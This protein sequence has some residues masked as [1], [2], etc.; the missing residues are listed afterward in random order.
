M[1][2]MLETIPEEINDFVSKTVVNYADITISMKEIHDGNV[3][4]NNQHG[5]GFCIKYGV[6]AINHKEAGSN[7]I[8][9][10]FTISD[11]EYSVKCIAHNANEKYLEGALEDEAIADMIKVIASSQKEGKR[12]ELQ[13]HYT[14]VGT[15]RL[16]LVHCIEL[17]DGFQVSQMTVNQFQEFK[18]LCSKYDTDPLSLMMRDDTLWAE[19]YAM[20]YLK[21]AI[22]LFC[23]SPKRKQDMIHVGIVSSHGEGKDHLIERVIQPLVPCRRAGSGKMATIPGL[24]GAMSGDD[25]NAIEVGLLPKMNHERVAISEFQTWGDETFGELMNMMANG[26]IEMQ[27]GALD[28]ERETTL[29]LLFLGNPPNYYTEDM[30]KRVMLD[31]FGKYTFQI[32]SRLTLIFTQLS[33]SDGKASQRIRNAII[34]AMDGDFQDSEIAEQVAKWR[35]FF[36]EYLRFVSHMTPKLRH[37]AGSINGTYDEIEQKPH[38]KDAFC[39][40]TA[41]DNRKYQ[42]FANL[43]RGFARLM[44]D[45][46]IELAHL[47]SAAQIFELSLETLTEKFPTKAWANGVDERLLELYDCIMEKCPVG[48]NKREIQKECSISNDELITLTKLKALTRFDDGT[49]FVNADWKKELEI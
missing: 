14:N 37:F 20:D 32:I 48:H 26:Q 39:I 7:K 13:G 8:M 25:L 49:Y 33:L 9:L 24:F 34:S 2:I 12:V 17:D 36:R 1:D 22:L 4:G 31:A 28:V 29:N 3:F 43:V 35:K 18:S 44:G 6:K 15:K 40:R 5:S 41:T 10:E 47:I 21:K 46:T 19:L 42:E 23:L 16:F 30:D 38:F 11:G 45:D 27:K